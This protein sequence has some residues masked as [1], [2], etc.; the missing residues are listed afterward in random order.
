M[1]LCLQAHS[2][3]L[4]CHNILSLRPQGALENFIQVLFSKCMVVE[5]SSVGDEV[6]ADIAQ[7]GLKSLR[8]G[9]TRES[10]HPF[11]L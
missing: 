1:K 5:E 6:D 11:T 10:H 2:V 4:G 9:N 3:F 8:R 7:G